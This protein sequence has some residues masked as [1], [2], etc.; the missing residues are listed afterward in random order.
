MRVKVKRLTETAILPQYA[1]EGDIGADLFSD[2]Q[3]TIPPRSRGVVKTGLALE[4]PDSFTGYARVAPRSGLG[5]KGIDV[6][7]GVIDRGYRGEVG[8]ILINQTDLAFDVKYGDKIAQLIF[9]VADTAHFLEVE[10]LTQTK[11][12]ETG[13]GSTG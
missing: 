12:G 13:F 5:S 2:H 11:R 1:H 6:A 3:L 8:V 9:E 10:D 4:I 7:A